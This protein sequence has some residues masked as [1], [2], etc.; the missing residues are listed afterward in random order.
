MNLHDILIDTGSLLHV[1][2][3]GAGARLLQR[4]WETPGASRYLVGSATPYGHTQLRSF[5]GFAPEGSSVSLEVAIEMAMASYVQAAE[6]RSTQELTGSPVGLGLTAAVASDRL[7]RGE[8]RAHLAVVARSGVRAVPLPLR[9]DS[10]IEARRRHDEA[11]AEAALGLLRAAVEGANAGVDASADAVEALF[12]RPVF[13][14]DGTR[15]ESTSTGLYLP[16]TLNPLHA[17]HRAMLCAAEREVGAGARGSYLV[18]TTSVHKPRLSVPEML[19]RVGMAR[20]ERWHRQ[21]RAIEFS[22]NDPLFVDKA[23]QRPGSTFVI[24]ADTMAR[25]L[26][27]CWGPSRDQVLT[28]LRNHRAT[29]LVMGRQ[30][31]GRWLTCRDIPVPFPFGLLFRPLEGRV[32]L[33][34]RELRRATA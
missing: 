7:P 19:D 28:D 30:V 2:C 1:S 9:K 33:S 6:L 23:R 29:F 15:L 21:A 11:I 16:A 14:L 18:T 10:G 20:A 32:D 27:P 17:G 26:D 4:L 24:G 22:R 3:T 13:E 8:Q 34:S 5:L 25:M 31:E 12:A